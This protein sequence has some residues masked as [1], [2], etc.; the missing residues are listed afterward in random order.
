[1]LGGVPTSVTRPPRSEAKAS[2]MR[3]ADG[4]IPPWRDIRIAVG[5]RTASAPT[6]L[7]NAESPAASP[8]VAAIWRVGEVPALVSQRAMRST[9]PEFSRPR[10]ATSTAATVTTAG[11]PKSAN[12]CSPGMT[13]PSTSANSARSATASYRHRPHTKKTNVTAST[14]TTSN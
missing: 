4:P 1:M 12:A 8:E 3:M 9:A 2:G 6:L 11:W 14:S 10:L 5:I 13:P 7:M